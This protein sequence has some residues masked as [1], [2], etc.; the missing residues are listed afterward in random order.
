VR[1]IRKPFG[2]KS[3]QAEGH[4]PTRSHGPGVVP[5]R[6]ESS[7]EREIALSLSLQKLHLMAAGARVTG[8]SD[9]ASVD[10][11]SAEMA[12]W[13]VPHVERITEAERLFA[14]GDTGGALSMFLSLPQAA[15]VQMNIGVCYA[16][17]GDTRNAA[18]WLGKSA[19]CAPARLRPRVEENLRLLEERHAATGQALTAVD[20]TRPEPGEV[21]RVVRLVLV[22]DG[23][24]PTGEDLASVNGFL[25]QSRPDL[26]LGE[27]YHY[28][29]ACVEWK[30]GVPA[31]HVG[32]SMMCAVLDSEWGDALLKYHF[33]DD[34]A[35][36]AKVFFVD[37]PEEE[38]RRLAAIVSTAVP[39]EEGRDSR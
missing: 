27:E 1:W 20:P 13:A 31:E 15:I 33:R 7:E 18:H 9:D 28:R 24:T 39:A 14:A 10:V 8:L 26:F 23:F 11:V 16:E 35:S 5:S 38:H 21:H 22:G 2:A 34:N 29:G 36:G 17:L 37:I 19:Q 3:D 25:Q 30:G 6:L 32:K 4:D 12:R